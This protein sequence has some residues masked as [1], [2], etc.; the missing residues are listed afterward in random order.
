[1]KIGNNFL[2]IGD[3][4]WVPECIEYKICACFFCLNGSNRV[5]LVTHVDSESTFTAWFDI[6]KWDF[7][8]E[9]IGRDGIFGVEIISEGW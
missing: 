7:S 8:R 3:M 9:D 5:G 6:G 1:M 2:K 4:V